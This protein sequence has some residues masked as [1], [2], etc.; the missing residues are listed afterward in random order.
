M[1]TARL[2]CVD[3]RGPKVYARDEKKY[4][5]TAPGT[6]LTLVSDPV[7]LAG[8]LAEMRL[9]NSVDRLDILD[10][11]DHWDS[12]GNGHG[13]KAYGA[14]KG[15]DSLAVHEAHLRQA[16]DLILDDPELAHVQIRLWLRDLDTGT[17]IAVGV[18]QPAEMAA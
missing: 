16:R 1:A 15:D 12:A 17:L 4:T 14:L 8:K 10:I 3:G 2:V 7:I 18:E 5:F 6:S 11:E 13:C 9:I